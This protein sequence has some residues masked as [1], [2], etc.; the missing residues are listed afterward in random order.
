MNFLIDIGHPAHV[1]LYRNLYFRLREKGHTVVVTVKNLSSATQLLA[2]YG[3][4]YITMPEKPDALLG[5]I[6]KQAW[7][8]LKLLQA[9]RENEIA[10]A[11]GSSATIAHI[12][13][14]SKVKS[15]VFDDDDDE[16]EPLVA[17]FVNPFASSLLSPNVLQGKRRRRDTVYYPA[18]HELAYLH[19]NHFR[20][21]PAVLAESGLKE[22][23]P[24]FIL[25]FNV[26]KAHHDTGVKGLSPEQ[27]L[28][29]VEILK[30]HGAIFITTEREIEP[31]LQEYQMK[32]SPQK[33]HSLLAYAAIFIGDS[34][35]MASEAAVLGVPSL[36]CNTFAGRISYLEEQEKKYGL[37]FGYHPGDFDK[38]V[39]KLKTLLAMPNLKEEWQRRRRAMLADKIDLSAFMAWFVENYPRSAQA[40]K[41]DP[42]YAGRFSPAQIA[43]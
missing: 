23:S 43:Q 13:C 30:P 6:W 15:I 21:D 18:Y 10:V 42:E 38:L 22:G 4:P 11:V 39:W 29:L 8:N 5:K 17:R 25:R 12:S 1:H 26:F 20:P 40:L 16:V 24:F 34:Q 3:I 2:S 14:I 35:T 7:F 9:C 32:V 33:A 37:T 27:K 31:E 19:P 41:D 28:K 36:R